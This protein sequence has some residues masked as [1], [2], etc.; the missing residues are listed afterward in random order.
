MEKIEIPHDLLL[1]LSCI[2]CHQ[3]QKSIYYPCERKR[4]KNYVSGK[5][6]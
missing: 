3:I 5:F 2:Y 1:S 6:K 4:K